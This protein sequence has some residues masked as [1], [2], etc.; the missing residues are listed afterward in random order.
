MESERHICVGGRR[1]RV[2]RSGIGP[3]I[4]LLNGIG[5]SPA[6]WL[7]L[8]RYLDGFECIGVS[9][10]GSR[11]GIAAQPVLSMRK[12]AALAGDLLDEL[13][14]GRVDV[15]G[16]SFGGMIAQ[17]LAC[18]APER[19]RSLML[20]S[21]SCGLGG[22]PSN[23]LSWWNAMLGDVSPSSSVKGPQWL[24]RQWFGVMRREIG[25]GWTNCLRLSAFAQPMAAAS[26]W[27]SLSWL[28]QLTQETLVITGTADALVPPENA[29]ILAARLPR[30]QLYR[31]R[32]GGHLC[33][34]DR[35]EEVGPVIANFV[36]PLEATANDEA[37]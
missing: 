4:L 1:L 9:I 26:L 17:Q 2:R 35:L 15:L 18:D 11:D 20:V 19:V 36:R 8:E 5:M 7:P 25:V 6:T 33:L 13:D 37:V 29:N 14:I 10:P 27:S 24:A 16:F 22:T 34:F 12:F 30:A 28:A 32:G 3:P 21:T 31:V 23:P